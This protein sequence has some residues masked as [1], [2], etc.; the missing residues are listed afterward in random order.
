MNE[1][2]TDYADD[3]IKGLINNTLNSFSDPDAFKN[4]NIFKFKHKNGC[5]FIDNINSIKNF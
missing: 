3:F 4:L 5:L 1:I 2:K